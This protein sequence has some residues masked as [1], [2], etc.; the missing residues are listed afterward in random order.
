MD[1]LLSKTIERIYKIPNLVDSFKNSFRV[2]CSAQGTRMS[3]GDEG[4]LQVATGDQYRN[5]AIASV[6]L[7]RPY[8]NGR[9]ITLVTDT[10]ELIPDKLFDNIVLHPQPLM[11]YRDKILPLLYLPYKR[12][13]FLDTDLEILSTIEDIFK[14]L[15]SFDLVGCHAPVRWSDW[16]DDKVPEGFSELNSGVLGFQRS[17][18]QRALIKTWLKLYDKVGI[19]FDQATLRSALWSVSNSR[20]L[21][22][23]VL[24]PE[25][26]LRTP[27]P[28]LTGARMSVKIL[29][30]RVPDEDRQR[31]H[32]Y[33]N[34]N[35]DQFRSSSS[36]PTGQN[37]Q[38]LPYS[39][40]LDMP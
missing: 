34:N 6:K 32:N 11:C 4:V 18:R 7:I 31:L 28:W 15:R 16:R 1:T 9:P 23:W 38:I 20:G 33:L 37:Q 17:P 21:R 26:N 24:P 29:H 3:L 10:P 35:I 13:L 2:R 27:K 40:K 39:K 12:T 19:A 8:L 30:G 25:Y 22:T 36:F 5:E 14:I